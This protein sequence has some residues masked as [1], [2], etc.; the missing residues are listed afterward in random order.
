MANKMKFS[1]DNPL[2]NAILYILVGVLLCIFRASV[3]DWAMTAIGIV[4]IV[5]GVLEAIQGELIE[6][7]VTAAIGAVVILG[8]WLFLGII[9]LVLGVALA[10]KGVLELI[11]ALGS[12]KLSI[13]A[14]VSS[15][16]TVVIGVMLAI[17]NWV[18]IDWFFIIIGVILIVDGA[19]A[20]LGMI[21]K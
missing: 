18:L 10:V 12:K 21:K 15:V 2:V 3:L 19:L 6:G 5:V 1:K 8:G 4:L 16:V 9:L 14:L 13:P 20:A 7:I 17:G 11:K